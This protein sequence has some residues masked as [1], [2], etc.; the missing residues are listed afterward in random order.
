MVRR[1]V[2]VVLLLSMTVSKHGG[3]GRERELS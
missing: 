3:A 1:A 2:H